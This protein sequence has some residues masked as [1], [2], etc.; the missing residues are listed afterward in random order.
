MQQNYANVAP[1]KTRE[2][3]K[4]GRI[5]GKCAKVSP[6]ELEEYLKIEKKCTHSYITVERMFS[7]EKIKLEKQRIE[8]PDSEVS[9]K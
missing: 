5:T 7:V 6:S 1:E 8:G 3:K 4:R 2:E 9:E